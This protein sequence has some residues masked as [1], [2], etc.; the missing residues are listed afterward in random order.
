MSIEMEESPI[1]VSLQVRSLRLEFYTTVVII[2]K[3]FSSCSVKHYLPHYVRESISHE[4]HLFGSELINDR[5]STILE[6]VEMSMSP[7]VD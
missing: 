3:R 1:T 5:F 6:Q 2:T 4:S 7:W